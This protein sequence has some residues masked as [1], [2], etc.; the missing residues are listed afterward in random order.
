MKSILA[1]SRMSKDG[2]RLLDD[3]VLVF[4]GH[5]RHPT[6]EGPKLYKRKGFYYI[7]APAGGV[8]TGWQLVLRSKNIYG[9]Y[10][11][12]VVLG[13]FESLG[14]CDQAIHDRVALVTPSPASVS[15][16]HLS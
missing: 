9:P 1:I 11:D 7:S 6:I 5:A 3:G 2:K 16:A 4:D 15:R 12:K 14:E 8:P 10:E 13:P